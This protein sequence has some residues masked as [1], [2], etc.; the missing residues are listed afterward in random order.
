MAAELGKA[1]L[2][3]NEELQ[4]RNEEIIQETGAK[5]ENVEQEKY[6]IQQNY[7]LKER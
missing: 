5:L 6:V 2:E 4:R 3:Q 7:A 1:L